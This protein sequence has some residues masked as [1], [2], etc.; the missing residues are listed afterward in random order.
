MFLTSHPLCTTQAAC[1][2]LLV[3]PLQVPMLY[4]IY[5]LLIV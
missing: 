1:L 4:G 5:D 3:W 2:L